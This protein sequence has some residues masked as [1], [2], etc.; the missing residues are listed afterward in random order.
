MADGSD[1]SGVWETDRGRALRWS[2]ADGASHA[3]MVGVGESF[4]GALAVELGHRAEALALLLTLP[5]LVGSASQLASGSLT[6]LL[7]SRRR[8]VVVGAVLQALSHVAFMGI[9]LFGV[10]SFSALLAAKMMFWV[11]GSLIA[12]A[13]GAWMATLTENVDRERFFARRSAIAQVCLLVAFLGAG[14]GLHL[15]ERYGLHRVLPVFVVLHSI[16]VVARL[17]SAFALYRQDEGR[18]P[19]LSR[20]S[21]PD[22]AWLRLRQAAREGRW[23]TPAYLAA[24]LFGAYAAVPFFTPYMLTELKLG[25]LEFTALTAAPILSKIG[26]YPLLHRI[27]R[28]LSLRSMLL[29]SGLGISAVSFLWAG[30]REFEMLFAAQLLSGVVWAGLEFSSFQCLLGASPAECR[31][32]FLSLSNSLTG[33]VQ[34]VSALLAGVLLSRYHL[35]YQTIFLLSGIGRALPVVLAHAMIE[36]PRVQRLPALLMQIVSIRPAGGAVMRTALLHDGESAE[37]RAAS[38]AQ[39]SA[40]QTATRHAA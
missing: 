21:T 17:L 39:S 15:G 16:A 37:G 8:L 19:A 25:Y 35:S 10:R 36:A 34:L 5:L 30:T 27:R 29:A 3:V 38:T 31:L 11:S 24:L 18:A 28:L 20:D 23:R 4:L 32:E 26:T 14:A 2:V 1:T 13:W 40:A 9:A 22:S 7:G 12:P 6:R 33:S